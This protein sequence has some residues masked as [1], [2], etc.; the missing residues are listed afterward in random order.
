MTASPTIAKL[1]AM[2]L[3]AFRGDNLTN[4]FASDFMSYNP[5]PPQPRQ[6]SPQANRTLNESSP[7]AADHQS[8]WD[9]KVD[10]ALSITSQG[11]SLLA[12]DEKTKV[13]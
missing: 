9:S 8:P 1:N 10:R 11:S 13:A 12:Y 5:N 4:A 3:F 7:S 6:P 2:T